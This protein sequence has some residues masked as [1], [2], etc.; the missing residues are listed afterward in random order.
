MD[1]VNIVNTLCLDDLVFIDDGLISLKVIQKGVD[2][3]ITGQCNRKPAPI[4]VT[5]PQRVLT[6]LKSYLLG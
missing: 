2:Y 5:L 4:T 1:Y 6:T 3:L